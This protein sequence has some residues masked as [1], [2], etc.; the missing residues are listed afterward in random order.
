MLEPHWQERGIGE[1]AVAPAY[2]QHLAILCDLGLEQRASQNGAD[3]DAHDSGGNPYRRRAL[4][5]PVCRG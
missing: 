2:T 3:E 5:T 4:L 1:D